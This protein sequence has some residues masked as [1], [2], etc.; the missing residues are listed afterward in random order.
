MTSE[1]V[2]QATDF[3]RYI[4]DQLCTEKD[5]INVEK[6]EDEL[7][8]LITIQVA[9]ADMGKL[10]G[11]QGSTISALRTLVRVIGARE[12]QRINLKVLDVS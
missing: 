8:I 10:I 6:K 1:S 2:K 11:K 12:N 5:A 3:I 9:E 4:L 7:G